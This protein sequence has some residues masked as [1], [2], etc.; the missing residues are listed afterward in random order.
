[1]TGEISW[2]GKAGGR[3]ERKHPPNCTVSDLAPSRFLA[4]RAKQREVEAKYGFRLGVPCRTPEQKE[5]RRRYM[6]DWQRRYRAKQPVEERR[7]Y[8][9]AWHLRKRLEKRLGRPPT[10][11]EIAAEVAAKE[12]R[13]VR[14]EERRV[15]AKER[16][17]FTLGTVPLEMSL[18]EAEARKRYESECSREW[19]KAHAERVRELRRQSYQRTK[20]AA[21]RKREAAA[22][23]R[24]RCLAALAKARERQ[25]ELREEAKRLERE[26]RR[27]EALERF[28]C[29][30]DAKPRTAEERRAQNLY[31]LTV[32]REKCA[33]KRARRKKRREE[34]ERREREAARTVREKRIREREEAQ[35]ARVAEI[36]NARETFAAEREANRAAYFAALA[37]RGEREMGNGERG[38][39]NGE[40]GM[41]N[42]E[43]AESHPAPTPSQPSF[44]IPPVEP[45]SGIIGTGGGEDDDQE[46]RI[47]E[48]A[49]QAAREASE[50]QREATR[51]AREAERQAAKQAKQAAREAEAAER[52]ALLKQAYE[53]FAYKVRAYKNGLERARRSMG[54]PTKKRK[55]TPEERKRWSIYLRESRKEFDDW[56]V[57]RMRRDLDKAARAKRREHRRLVSEGKAEPSAEQLERQKRRHDKQMAYNREYRRRKRAEALAAAQAKWTPAQWAEWEKR[58][59]AKNRHTPAWLVG[60][61]VKRL[62]AESGVSADDVTERLIETGG[63]DFLMAGAQAMGRSRLARKGA[64]AAAARALMFH[65]DPDHASLFGGRTKD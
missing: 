57:G 49:E 62:A 54:L 61:V 60:E 6:S 14:H 47:R 44:I 35:A 3:R 11:E 59:A 9:T 42:G 10:E 34:A 53:K 12:E 28:G 40:R 13:R 39:G 4:F 25:R 20:E 58:Q 27:R 16:Y 38:M 63:I 21:K 23:R 46:R 52:K 48:E 15:A 19:R 41:G 2:S 17:G 43:N 32:A 56:L 29:D 8:M 50:A 31:W 36:R 22:A 18:E 51:K 64:V 37:E 26:R 24:E 7:A 45:P 5:G 55:W 33:E 65:L 30:I 1:M